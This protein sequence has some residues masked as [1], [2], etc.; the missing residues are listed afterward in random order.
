[1]DPYDDLSKIIKNKKF[2][3]K[4]NTKIFYPFKTVQIGKKYFQ[5]MN[6][7]QRRANNL[8][9]SALKEK[10]IFDGI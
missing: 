2:F 5:K 10:I 8:L 9:S 1:M 3:K 6:I 7:S 4:K